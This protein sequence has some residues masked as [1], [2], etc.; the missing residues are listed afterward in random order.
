MRLNQIGQLTLH[1]NDADTAADFYCTTLGL[2]L[3]FQFGNMLFFDCA[4]VRLFIECSAKE[5]K[6]NNAIY[7]KSLDLA[8][9]YHEL[10]SA[11]VAIVDEPHLIAPM[12]DHDLW[13]FFFKD[14]SGN[15]LALMQECP[16]GFAPWPGG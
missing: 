7:F 15:L 1:C 5:H 13:M 8:A 14:P 4:G 11:G 10:K 6:E 16:K 9:S 12:M 3:L 2:K